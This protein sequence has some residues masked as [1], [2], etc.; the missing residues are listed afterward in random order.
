MEPL[1][2]HLE[3]AGAVPDGHVVDQGVQR[4]EPPGRDLG[5]DRGAH[6]LRHCHHHVGG[7]IARRDRVDRDAETRV[8]ARQRNGEAVHAGLR[9]GVVGLAVL[10]LEA[11]DRT[12]LH[13]PAPLARAHALYHRTGDVE[14]GVE[15][16]A[17]DLVPLHRRHAMERGVARDA[18]VVDQ[19]LDRAELVFD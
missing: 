4:A 5:D 17:D 7:D 19:D 10:A 2:R 12:D 13:D 9:G 14:A 8:L 18:G 16:G 15:V 3:D 6:V 11:V 1:G